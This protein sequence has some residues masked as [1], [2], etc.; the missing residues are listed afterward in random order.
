[1]EGQTRTIKLTKDDPEVFR[2]FFHWM[3]SGKLY[4]RLLPDKNIPLTSTTICSIYLF[5]DIRG[6]PELCNAAVDLLFQKH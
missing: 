3:S 2:V 1:V 6:I 4:S 5:G